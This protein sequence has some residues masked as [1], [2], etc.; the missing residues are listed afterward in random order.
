[1]D[2]DEWMIC[3]LPQEQTQS[4]GGWVCDS[5]CLCGDGQLERSASIVCIV[6][7]CVL[8]AS[9]IRLLPLEADHQ[10]TNPHA[11]NP[12]LSALQIFGIV[13]AIKELH[14][15]LDCSCS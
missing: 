4:K 8:W 3:V 7:L 12:S 10:T 2:G 9:W 14:S 15:H 5:W 13:G 1:M 11:M 6:G